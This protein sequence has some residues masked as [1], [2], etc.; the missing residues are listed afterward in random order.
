M[1]GGWSQACGTDRVSSLWRWVGEFNKVNGQG[2]VKGFALQNNHS[3]DS[4]FGR[5]PVSGAMGGERQCW[6]FSSFAVSLCGDPIGGVQAPKSFAPG[7]LRM[8]AVL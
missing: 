7:P 2:D 5:A 4:V 1:N 6:H 3:V 8:G